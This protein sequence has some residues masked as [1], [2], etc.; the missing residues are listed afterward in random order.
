MT[1]S[2]RVTRQNFITATWVEWRRRCP[3]VPSFAEQLA[4]LRT[5]GHF[6]HA[7]DV[8]SGRLTVTNVVDAAT[9]RIVRSAA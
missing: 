8:E 7:A 4:M 5:F 6:Y 3:E 9:A 1:A 2:T